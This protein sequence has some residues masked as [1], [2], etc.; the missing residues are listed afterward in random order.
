MSGSLTRLGSYHIPLTYTEKKHNSINE[1]IL[2]SCA[3]TERHV[4][5]TQNKHINARNHTHTC[6]VVLKPKAAT[7]KTLAVPPS[8]SLHL[9]PPPSTPLHPPPP[10]SPSVTDC[11]PRSRSLLRRSPLDVRQL[12]TPVGNRRAWTESSRPSSRLTCDGHCGGDLPTF[13]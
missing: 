4:N 3:N 11:T 7:Q 2:T 13:G 5:Q 12:Y 1:W 10:A 9:P 8:T 6:I